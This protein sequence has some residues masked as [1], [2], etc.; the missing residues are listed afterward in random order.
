MH[1]QRVQPGAAGLVAIVAVARV[2]PRAAAALQV[3]P[4]GLLRD[5]VVAVIVFGCV[6]LYGGNWMGSGWINGI[7]FV[8][9]V[10]RTPALL[11]KTRRRRRGGRA[12]GLPGRRT[13]ILPGPA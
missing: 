4:R 2:G 10:S 9:A 13:P 3:P 8:W 12:R 5:G 11:R 1:R 7:K 6:V